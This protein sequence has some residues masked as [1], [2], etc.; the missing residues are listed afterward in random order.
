[1]EQQTQMTISAA[2]SL[3]VRAMERLSRTSSA[4]EGVAIRRAVTT[5]RHAWP[6]A[7]QLSEESEE[8]EER[9]TANGPARLV[10]GIAEPSST[11]KEALKEWGAELIQRRRAAG[12]SRAVLAERANLSESTLRNVETGR[13]APTRTTVMHLQSVPEL[14]IEATP[15]EN[16]IVDHRRLKPGFFPNCWLT[17]EYDALHPV[18]GDV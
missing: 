15:T 12:L 17:P 7:A 16:Q 4:S 10:A 5:L 14:R 2:F 18:L 6:K 9:P 11:R 1:M 3:T 8:P 13:R